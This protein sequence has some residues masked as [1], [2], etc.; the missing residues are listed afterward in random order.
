LDSP[1]AS[2]NFN[3]KSDETEK[4]RHGEKAD[5]DPDEI[6]EDIDEYYS[7]E[8]NPCHPFARETHDR[9][10]CGTKAK[11][12]I[13]FRMLNDM[14][15]FMGG[16]SGGRYGPLTVDG[17]A[18]IDCLCLRIVMIREIAGNGYDIDIGDSIVIEHLASHFSS[19]H[20]SRTEDLGILRETACQRLLDDETQHHHSY[21][22]EPDHMKIKLVWSN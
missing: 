18:Q 13:S 17:L 4:G 15:A 21:H 16:D 6:R 8:K 12:S 14:A 20:S 22:Y 19:G 3:R 7:G 9:H 10:K 2:V 1:A 5:S 11:R